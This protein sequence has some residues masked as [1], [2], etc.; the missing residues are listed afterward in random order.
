MHVL[1]K[2]VWNE[3]NKYIHWFL[4]I[5]DLIISLA[6]QK[7]MQVWFICHCCIWG[8]FICNLM[9]VVLFCENLL[10]FYDLF[11]VD[12]LD[13][14]E[15]VNPRNQWNPCGL[16]IVVKEISSLLQGR[17][18]RFLEGKT[19]TIQRWSPT[20]SLICNR[21]LQVQTPVQTNKNMR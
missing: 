14:I 1:S 12:I 2:F 5:I 10:L 7:S 16:L 4:N 11:I 17:H 9:V 19:P 15:Q 8:V 20:S 6:G 21:D 18:G 3:W 13:P